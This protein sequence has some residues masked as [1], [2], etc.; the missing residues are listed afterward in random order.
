MFQCSWHLGVTVQDLRLWRTLSD[1][2]H[3]WFHLSSVNAIAR[4]S[5]HAWSE[6]TWQVT[7]FG[8]YP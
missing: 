2:C 4:K 1:P 3:A 5:G 6:D 7:S 8:W